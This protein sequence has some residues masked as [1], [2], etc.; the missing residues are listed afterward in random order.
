M[1]QDPK[2]K[3]TVEKVLSSGR[4]DAKAGGSLVGAS[5]GDEFWKDLV[6]PHPEE[7]FQGGIRIRCTHTVHSNH[8]SRQ[9]NSLAAL[10]QTLSLSLS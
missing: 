7:R 9:P 3:E 4:F 1:F 5:H 8:K 10:P 2:L 6:S